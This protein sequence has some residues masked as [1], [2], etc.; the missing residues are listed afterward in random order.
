MG[1]HSD[2]RWPAEPGEAPD[3]QCRYKR[4]PRNRASSILE[5]P[6]WRAGSHIGLQSEGRDEYAEDSPCQNTQTLQ[7]NP[8]SIKRAVRPRWRVSLERRS[9]PRTSPFSS[10]PVAGMFLL[11]EGQGFVLQNHPK[12]GFINLQNFCT[13]KEIISK[14]KRQLAEWE[15]CWQL[16]TWSRGLIPQIREELI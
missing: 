15:K 11:R 9:G 14:M 6:A 10:G 4:P 2:H 13:W 7:G 8:T 3:R 16:V 12:R 5:A 1:W